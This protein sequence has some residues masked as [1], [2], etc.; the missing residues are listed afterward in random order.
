MKSKDFICFV[1]FIFVCCFAWLQATIAQNKNNF[2]A[3]SVLIHEKHLVFQL[4]DDSLCGRMAGTIYDR[5]TSN[6]IASYF[7]SLKLKNYLGKNIFQDFTLPGDS[8]KLLN[9]SNILVRTGNKKGPII[10]M[11][12][13]FDHIGM[14]GKL[15][16]NPLK[17]AVHN[18]ADDNASGM[19]VLIELASL[20]SQ[21]KKPEY[22]Y[23]FM[24]FSAHETGLF[25]SHAAIKM[26]GGDTSKVAIMINTD[27]VGRMDSSSMKLFYGTNKT[28]IDTMVTENPW[29]SLK[30]TLKE[31]P[32]G[33][34]S[35]FAEKNIPVLYLTTG[36]HDDY[37]KITDDPELINYKGMA[38][39][40]L[41][42]YS[43]I[44]NME[45]Q[46]KKNKKEKTVFY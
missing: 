6:I 14:G 33:D 43:F 16:R 24:A 28:A 20:I 1:C 4:A 25:G 5:K 38:Q 22:N 19:A 37:H 17:Y 15:S 7:K 41:F 3:D 35:A 26:L 12:A 8:G 21:M 39:V 27:M 42:I 23:V 30:L 2:S 18:G 44:S 31:L 34:H 13:H 32:A 36:M 45:E 40:T 29:T 46:A 10:I 9:S 11:G